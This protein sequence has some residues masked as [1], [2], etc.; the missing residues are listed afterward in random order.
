MVRNLEI[1]ESKIIDLNQRKR[2]MSRDARIERQKQARKQR[3]KTRVGMAVFAVALT[4]ASIAYNSNTRARADEPVITTD[5]VVTDDTIYADITDLNNL[6]IVLVNDGVQDS[7]IN[8]LSNKLASE[9]V[10]VE[11]VV[12]SYS[13]ENMNGSET[14]ISLLDY[15]NDGKTKVIGQYNE[16]DN[17]TDPLA[18][19]LNSCLKR[20][21]LVDVG[22]QC[23]I[24]GY[25]DNGNPTLKES[26][27]ENSLGEKG[28]SRFATIAV[29]ANTDVNKFTDS[30]TEGL[31]RFQEYVKESNDFD[32]ITRVA[33]GQTL[34]IIANNHNIPTDYLQLLNNRNDNRIYMDETLKVSEYPDI[35]TS[36]NIEINK[37]VQE[38][39]Y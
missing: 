17:Q 30:L 33:G 6:N 35:L 5:T 31:L 2:Q 13:I 9:G 1:N 21:G 14:Y 37:N 24:K 23:G 7:F 19:S 39:S 34:D 18:V 11:T 36:R 26:P 16:R 10:S 3:L 28:A 32:L 27:I 38:K 8:S 15:N 22:I 29:D 12:D 25:D 4:G 20:N